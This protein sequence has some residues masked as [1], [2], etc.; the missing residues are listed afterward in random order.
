MSGRG[1]PPLQSEA[2]DAHR[3]AVLPLFS[4]LPRRDVQQVARWADEIEVK[5]GTRLVDQGR[6]PHEFFV[7][8]EGTAAVSVDDLRVADLGPGEFFGEIALLETER[9]TASVVATSPM[10]LVVIHKRDFRVMH[11]QMPD[12]AERIRAAVA[13]RMPER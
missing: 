11:R 6:F 4:K 3:L 5:D 12:V 7:I 13:Q 1:I 2:V 8:E 10:R 9:R